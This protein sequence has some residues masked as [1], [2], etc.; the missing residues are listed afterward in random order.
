MKFLTFVALV[1]SV[2]ALSVQPKPAKINLAQSA[3]ASPSDSASDEDKHWNADDDF[4]LAQVGQ[5]NGSDSG[6][7][8][9]YERDEKYHNEEYTDAIGD[10]KSHLAQIRSKPNLA[11]VESSSGSD[12]DYERDEKYHNEEYTDAIGDYKS[13][14]AQIKSKA[15]Y[16]YER[17]PTF[18]EE[19]LAGGLTHH[20]MPNSLAQTQD[21]NS[22]IAVMNQMGQKIQGV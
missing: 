17:D 16:E 21:L 10:Y 11:Q 5:T 1:A 3:V 19:E 2:S 20:N 12:V 4:D 7:D 13:H 14:L 9:D 8:V 22:Y 18:H 15:K 6:S